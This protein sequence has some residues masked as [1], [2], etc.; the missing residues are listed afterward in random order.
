MH[1]LEETNKFKEVGKRMT[2]KEFSSCKNVKLPCLLK[3]CSGYNSLCERYSFGIDQLFVV[4]ETKTIDVVKMSEARSKGNTEVHE[5]PLQTDIFT[6]VPTL[7]SE[8]KSDPLRGGQI[9]LHQLLECMS[10]PK[11]VQVVFEFTANMGR[12]IPAGTLLFPQEVKKKKKELEKRVLVAKMEDG[13]SVNV[14]A[15][16]TAKFD[17]GNTAPFRLSL[18]VSVFP[19]SA[20][21]SH[22][23]MTFT[24]PA[25]LFRVWTR[26]FSYLE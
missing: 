7:D 15:D 3:V 10:L 13:F 19:S 21:S 5:I 25:Q 14:T 11:I 8:W 4:I 26:V 2:L 17:I 24:S 9:E 1:R 20:L 22:I 6:V 23:R 12:K 16:C 18:N